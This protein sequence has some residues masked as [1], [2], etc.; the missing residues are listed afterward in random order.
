VESGPAVIADGKITVTG[1]GTIW[2][3]AEQAGNETYLPASATLVFNLRQ[4]AVSLVGQYSDSPPIWDFA[5]NGNLLFAAS[6][7]FRSVHEQNGVR[8]FDVSDPALP[9]VPGARRF[10]E[11]LPCK[12]LGHR[13]YGVRRESPGF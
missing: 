12:N 3:K 1:S 11:N 9:P 10:A 8:I 7:A 6:G 5:L 2:V 4:A 13:Q